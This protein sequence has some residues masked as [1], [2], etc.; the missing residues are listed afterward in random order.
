VGNGAGF[1][2]RSQGA[3]LGLTRLE[4]FENRFK[5]QDYANRDTY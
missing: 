3:A 1:T 5:V 4:R 2:N